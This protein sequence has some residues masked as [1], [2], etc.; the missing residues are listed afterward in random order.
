MTTKIKKRK[1][2][3]PKVKGWKVKF[4]M[5]IKA[6]N[7]MEVKKITKEYFKKMPS[8]CKSETL[9]DGYFY[10]DTYMQP[11]KKKKEFKIPAEIIENKDGSADVIFL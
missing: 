10:I 5:V 11:R 9:S 3:E 4:Q 6:K 1:W 7:K 8:F 2:K